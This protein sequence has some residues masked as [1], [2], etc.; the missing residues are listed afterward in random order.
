LSSRAVSGLEWFDEHSYGRTFDWLGSV[1]N[2]T[3]KH[4]DHNNTF[5]VS[6]ELDEIRHLKP[7]INNIRRILDL[8]VDMQAVEH[9]IT[10]CFSDG[11]TINS[12]I[13]LPGIWNMFEAGIR[14]ILGQQISVSAARNLVETLVSSLGVQIRNCRLFPTAKSIMSS[15]LAFLKIPASRR[16]TLLNLAQHYLQS[17]EPNDP[18]QWLKLKGIGTW[19]VEY[20]QLRGLVSLIFF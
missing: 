8:D 11:F 10:S 14:A 7:I 9:D 12:G 4:I 18:Q 15:D 5:E 3:A 17:D 13:R 16:Q 2:F 1:G 20:S 19:T 6:I